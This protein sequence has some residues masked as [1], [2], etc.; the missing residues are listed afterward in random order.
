MDETFLQ[1]KRNAVQLIIKHKKLRTSMKF[2]CDI[3]SQYCLNGKMF[4]S[5][6]TYATIDKSKMNSY[7]NH[8]AQTNSVNLLFLFIL[9]YASKSTKINTAEREE[10]K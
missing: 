8:V 6:S 3:A 7:M 2:I 4:I 5:I 1:Y 10:L 9:L